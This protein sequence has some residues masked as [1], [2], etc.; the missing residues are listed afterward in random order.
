MI[1]V[2]NIRKKNSSWKLIGMKILMLRKKFWIDNY[3]ILN[4]KN[5]S[6]N[7]QRENT[8]LIFPF[9]VP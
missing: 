8:F 3:G 4:K 9:N 1:I 6:E 5:I 7:L 2:T